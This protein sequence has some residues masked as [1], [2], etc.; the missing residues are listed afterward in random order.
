MAARH[1]DVGY[2]RLLHF[3]A[4]GTWDGSPLE[5]ALLTEADRQVGGPEAWLIIDDT[6]LPK[7]GTHS[8]GVAPQYASMLGKN[9]N[10]RTLVSLTLVSREVPVMIGLRLF[11]P[12][13]GRV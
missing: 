5:A 6:S 13:S 10:C 2:D 7:R 11:L 8:V 1:R 12:A 4:S 3:I 9:A